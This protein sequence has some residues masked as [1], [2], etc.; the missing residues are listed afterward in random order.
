MNDELDPKDLED[1]TEEETIGEDGE[2]F[3]PKKIKKDFDD[4]DE[5]LDDLA[6]EED[7]DDSF[8]DKDEY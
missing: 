2:D 6:E 5:S 7:F 8:D 3:H 4:D 1:E